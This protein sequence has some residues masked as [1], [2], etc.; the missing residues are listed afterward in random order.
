MSA[1][2][3]NIIPYPSFIVWSMLYVNWPLFADG[4]GEFVLC[5]IVLY[6]DGNYDISSYQLTYLRKAKDLGNVSDLTKE[7]TDLPE[8]TH[9]DIVDL[10]VQM[11]VQTIPNTS[12][13]KS[14]DE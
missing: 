7:Y 9:Q 6:T 2:A 12:S 11:I 8:N 1:H 10:A 13:K 5:S 14:Q 3:G 4:I